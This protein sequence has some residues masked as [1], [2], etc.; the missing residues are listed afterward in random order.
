MYSMGCLLS[1]QATQCF[2]RGERSIDGQ[3]GYQQ[4]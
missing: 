1:M 4:Y 3:S 2:Y